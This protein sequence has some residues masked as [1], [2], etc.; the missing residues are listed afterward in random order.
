MNVKSWRDIPYELESK[1]PTTVDITFAEVKYANY[2][3]YENRGERLLWL[4]LTNADNGWAALGL[5]TDID[6]DYNGV[7]QINSSLSVGTASASSGFDGEGFTISIIH[8]SRQY[9]EMATYFLASGTITITDSGIT[10]NAKSHFGSTINATYS[11]T[12]TATP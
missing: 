4:N 8:K 1:T 2:Y 9:V 5:Y 6:D 10:I 12:F 3:D 7:Y 11:G